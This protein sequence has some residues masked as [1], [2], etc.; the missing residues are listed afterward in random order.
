MVSFLEHIQ[1]T[2]LSQVSYDWID[3]TL[4]ELD[5]NR[6]ES[7]AADPVS[8]GGLVLEVYQGVRPLLETLSLL[9]LIPASWRAAVHLFVMTLDQFDLSLK[10]GKELSEEVIS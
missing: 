2:A 4:H 10:A 3:D 8:H 9:P 1:Q 6:L 5:F 7:L